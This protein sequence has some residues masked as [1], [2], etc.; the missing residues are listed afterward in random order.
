MIYVLLSYFNYRL[1]FN[2]N[3]RTKFLNLAYIIGSRISSWCGI[4]ILMRNCFLTSN[5]FLL[6]GDLFRS[7]LSTLV[8]FSQLPTYFVNHTLY[9]FF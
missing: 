9:Q 4:Y 7:P 2:H 8:I 5:A 3:N 6:L 1:F